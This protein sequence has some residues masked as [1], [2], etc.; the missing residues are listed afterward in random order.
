M[1]YLLL[2]LG[3]IPEA[4]YLALFLIFTKKL[5]KH[6][7]L[8]TVLCVIEYLLLKYSFPFNWY[9]HIA[10]I[11]I[12][13]ITLKVIYKE[14]SQVTDIFIIL[15]SFAYLGLTSA[16]TF[17]VFSVVYPN[18]IVC[19]IVHRLILFITIILFN[20]KLSKIQEIYKKYWNRN[21]KPKRLKSVTFRCL[22]VV[23]FNILFIILNA[24]ML[25]AIFINNI[26]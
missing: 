5:D 21:N 12:L 11:F 3:Q 22:N 18:M 8:F 23:S 14:K 7:V 4:I 16:I 1:N 2:F 6:R 17:L 19:L 9:F 13:F 20:Y 24:C 10:L 25:Y 26:R 15:I